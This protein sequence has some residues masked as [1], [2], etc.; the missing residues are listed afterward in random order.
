MRK[1]YRGYAQACPLAKAAE[2]LCERWTLL[3]VRELAMG[4]RRF[5]ELRRGIPAVSPTMLSQRLRELEDGGVIVRVRAP[6]KK[7]SDAGS[8]EYE[9]TPPGQALGPI[10]GQ[11]SVWGHAHAINDLR[12]EDMEP[13]YLMWVAHKTL[14]LRDASR[15]RLVLC[16]E[17]VDAPAGRRRWW[18][19]VEGEDVELCFKHPGFP[20]DL[21]VRTKL[22]PM[23]MLIL[24]K[25][26]PREAM[27]SG[28]VAIDG[29][30][31]LVRGFPSWYP[32]TYE[33][34]EAA[35]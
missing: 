23:S 31:E 29:P 20:I 21:T 32:R 27:R 8:V 18:I 7:R 1:R 6:G 13:S 35:G 22:R 15:E 19:V 16:Y 11:L 26:S 33:Y 30:P 17:L 25:L 12:R 2:L 34:V 5:T 3:V 4:S 24:G 10:L 14:R 9:L 28:A